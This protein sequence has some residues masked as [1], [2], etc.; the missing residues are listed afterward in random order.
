[1]KVEICQAPVKIMHNRL[2]R[3]T[4]AAPASS[5]KH[6]HARGASG[7]TSPHQGEPGPN[8][9]FAQGWE[10]VQDGQDKAPPEPC[11]AALLADQARPPYA[12]R[13]GAHRCPKSGFGPTGTQNAGLGMQLLFVLHLNAK[14]AA[15]VV[16]QHEHGLGRTGRSQKD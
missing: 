14:T 12:I 15:S 4:T 5:S 9:V 10:P 6:V 8:T 16:S 13:Y 3:D 1:M 2:R 11:T 7:H